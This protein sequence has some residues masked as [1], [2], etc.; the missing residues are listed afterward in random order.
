MSETNDDTKWVPPYI[1]FQ[2]L[3]NLVQRLEANM[4]PRIDR[5][6][7]TGSGAAN[8]QT[9]NA[10]RALG[11]ID[12]A[13]VVQAPLIQ[14]AKNA[15]ERPRIVGD[16]LTTL[17][18]KPV[19]LGKI[20]AT[21]KQLEEAFEELGVT[22]D[23]RRK[24]IAFFLKAAKYAKLPMSPYFKTPSSRG[25]GAAPRKP[26]KPDGRPKTGDGGATGQNNPNPNASGT[27]AEPKI[28]TLRA[29]YIEMLLQKAESQDELDA[30]LLDRI[31]TLLGFSEGGEE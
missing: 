26:R 11:L 17:Y 19:E 14:L 31:E 20:N 29:K 3:L 8:T 4:P 13:G 2:N 21:Q 1:A 18:S 15:E 9:L 10:L 24:A 6:F 28:G 5:S 25:N 27:G 30:D 22:G 23:T 16:M 7:L 12:A